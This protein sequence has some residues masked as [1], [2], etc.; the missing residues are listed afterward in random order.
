ME[1]EIINNI[2]ILNDDIVHYQN[3]IHFVPLYT[4]YRMPIRFQIGHDY[5][6]NGGLD[7]II[8]TRISENEKNIISVSY[9][10]ESSI[11][12]FLQS[13]EKFIFE[14]FH[15]NQSRFELEN[16]SLACLENQF[17][18]I[19]KQKESSLCYTN[20]KFNPEQK[21]I[22]K[23]V[24]LK[25]E[26]IK[27]GSIEDLKTGQ[28]IIM[29]IHLKGFYFELNHN[30]KVQHFGICLSLISCLIYEQKAFYSFNIEIPD[31]LLKRKRQEEI[32]TNKEDNNDENEKTTFLTK[33]KKK[34]SDYE[35]QF[36]E[37][38]DNPDNLFF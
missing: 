15:K 1:N 18:P 37:T 30:K 29:D 38:E 20:V 5:Q 12:L 33:R 3:N 14:L 13:L 32:E 11:Y 8:I 7:T 35:K 6:T 36:N 31:R 10:K 19:V 2:F 22:V 24:T 26:I 23:M 17:T 28:F 25:D 21:P 34:Q 4:K 16:K 27:D 9:L